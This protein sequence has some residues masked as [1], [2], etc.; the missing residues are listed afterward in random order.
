MKRTTYLA[1]SGAAIAIVLFVAGFTAGGMFSR[2]CILGLSPLL[3]QI[4]PG[5][6]QPTK[7]YDIPAAT[8]LSP[9]STFY[10][11]RKRIKSDYVYP[12]EDDKTLTYGAIRGMLSSL[13]DPYSRFLDPEEFREFRTESEGHFDGIGA[14]LEMRTD[15]NGRGQVTVSSILPGGPSSKTN[16]RPLDRIMKVD[17]KLTDGLSLNE[18]VRQIRGKRGTSVTLTLA[19]DGVEGNFD[20]EIERA[21]IDLPTVEREMLDDKIGYIWLR[22][23]NQT[24]AS[25]MSEAVEYLMA[26]GMKGLLLD[27]SQDPGGILDVA[28]NVAGLF[29]D[30]GPVVYVKG[31][32]TEPH[33]L[34]AGPGTVL[35]EDI[36][37]IVLVDHGSASASEILA[38]ALQERSRAEVAGHHT[39][40]KSKV[41]TII[42]LRDG[43]A[44]FLST[45]VYLTPEFTDLGIE[46]EDGKRGVRPAHV[47]PDPDP[48]PEVEF[49]FED[50]HKQQINRAVEILKAKMGA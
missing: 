49:V 45:A 35:P 21:N 22:T 39:F 20:V 46:G 11:V 18:V 48:D 28:V 38:G 4:A 25:K 6:Y 14:V 9:I 19:R 8:D 42:E 1:I 32:D 13:E 12:L 31:R 47:F 10:E 2:S 33:P 17:G 36:P 37:M 30:G 5:V 24:A 50:W 23:F 27:L 7:D 40:G 16:M 34:N 26:Q 43:S 15:A 3:A 29:L 41:Q 44:L